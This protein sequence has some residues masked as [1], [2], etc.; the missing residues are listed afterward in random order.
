L[1]ER[2][3]GYFKSQIERGWDMTIQDLLSRVSVVFQRLREGKE[4]LQ[5]A[6]TAILVKISQFA[7]EKEWEI[8]KMKDESDG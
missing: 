3:D 7:A 5:A 1:R 2:V 4:S 6:E 8:E